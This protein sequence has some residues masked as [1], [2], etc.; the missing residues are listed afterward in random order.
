MGEKKN[1]WGVGTKGFV[2][3]RGSPSHEQ[4]EFLYPMIKEADLAHLT[5]CSSARKE[6]GAGRGIVLMLE[7]CF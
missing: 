4:V 6:N 5:T 2:P 3:Q 1:S 7:S